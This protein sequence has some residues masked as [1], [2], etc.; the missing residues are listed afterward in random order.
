MR[1]PR[2]PAKAIMRID[3][4][5]AVVSLGHVRSSPVVPAATRVLLGVDDGTAVDPE[6]FE[7]RRKDVVIKASPRSQIG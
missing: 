6:L 4:V 5:L 7:R 1:Q 2:L 3:L